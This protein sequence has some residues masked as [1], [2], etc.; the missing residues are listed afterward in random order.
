MSFWGKYDIDIIP[1]SDCAAASAAVFLCDGTG[2]A[3][4]IASQTASAYALA[5]AD[6]IAYCVLT[7]PSAKAHATAAARARAEIWVSAYFDALTQ[8]ISCVKCSEWGY[9][10]GYI[11]K[12]VFLEAITRAEV[13]V[14][15]VSQRRC[16]CQ[17]NMHSDSCLC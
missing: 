4:S 14:C 17:T 3:E 13:K 12:W 15:R 9:S 8:A 16:M 6:A 10:W 11:K 1:R 7:G 5:V 2:S